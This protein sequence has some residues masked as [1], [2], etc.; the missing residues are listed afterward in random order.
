MQTVQF[1][2][3]IHFRVSKLKKKN[4]EIREKI[5]VYKGAIASLTGP[6]HCATNLHGNC[7]RRP[8]DSDCG[9]GIKR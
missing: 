1:Q 9:L 3:S 2:F 7:E 5:N 6:L 4:K 8:T